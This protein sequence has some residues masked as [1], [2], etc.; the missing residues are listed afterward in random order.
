MESVRV[1]SSEHVSVIVYSLTSAVPET[2]LLPSPSFGVISVPMRFPS[3][4]STLT[5]TSAQA[6]GS[7]R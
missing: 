3:M 5:S 2:V 1:A 6:L 7:P 4:S